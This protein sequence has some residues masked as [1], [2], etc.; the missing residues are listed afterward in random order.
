MASA[1]AKELAAGVSVADWTLPSLHLKRF[2]ITIRGVRRIRELVRQRRPHLVHAHFLGPGAWYASL[3]GCRP[4]VVSVMG[5]GDVRGTEWRPQSLVDRL[6]TPHTL[7]RSDL[8]TCWSTNLARAV[9]PLVPWRT[10]VEVVLGGVDLGVFRRHPDANEV[11]RRL[12]LATNDF[13]IFAPRLFWPL[14]N[15]ETIVRAMPQIL[16]TEPRARLVLVKYRAAAYPE[17]EARIEGL[18]DELGIRPACASSPRSPTQTCQPT[19]APWIA[20]CPC[21][22]AMARR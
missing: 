15:I 22:A 14:Q 11:R 1:A 7:R 9:R 12:N 17:H 19:T 5:G 6:L 3:A 13:V 18:I 20:R 2:W 8:V 21:P 4:L 16:S 10:R